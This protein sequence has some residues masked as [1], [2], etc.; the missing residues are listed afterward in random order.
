M[1]TAGTDAPLT[2]SE[3]NRQLG[4]FLSGTPG[5]SS[6][7]LLL[8]RTVPVAR[9]AVLEHAALNFDLAIKAHLTQPPDAQPQPLDKAL[10]VWRTCTRMINYLF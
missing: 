10:Q 9:D 2:A 8:L 4:I 3:L 7:G 1:A 6:A 5:S